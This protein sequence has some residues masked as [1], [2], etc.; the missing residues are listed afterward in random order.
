MLKDAT[1]ACAS[2]LL[3]EQYAQYN[4]TSVE[5]GHRRA[6]LA[7]SGLRSL[8]ISKEQDLITALVLGISMVTFA[9]HVADGQPFL[10]SH[11]TL[12]LVKP[13]YQTLLSMDP[14][15]M[16][17]LMCLVSMETFECLLRSEMPTI[18]VGEHD[19]TNVVDRYIG[20]SSSLFAHIYDVC[21]ASHL[22]KINGGSRGMD[23]EMVE[24]LRKIQDSLEQ[25]KAMPPPDVLERFTQ[26][27][28]AG[29]LSQAEIL[30]LA[31]LLIVHRIRHPSGK[32][33]E[34]ALQLSRAITTEIDMV[35]LSTGRSIPCT[36]L[37]YTVACF[38]ITGTEARAAAVSK[39]HEV[40]TFSRQ[41]QLQVERSLSL[42]W[43]ARDRGDQIYWFDL[44]NYIRKT[45]ST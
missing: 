14:S 33:D 28:V 16:D 45:S 19:R 15:I 10:I 30:R 37:P 9:M 13:V 2:V 21:E 20:L 8:Q 34:E 35:L 17:F 11:Y 5:I 22:M 32:C 41:S 1:L 40:V 43:G 18:R 42:V 36:S 24:R 27:E 4:K 7:V 12:T 38:E 39:I 3:G 6:A 25:W 26:S 29:M 31:A 23:M 44:G